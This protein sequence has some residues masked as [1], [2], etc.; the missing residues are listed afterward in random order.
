MPGRLS[1]PLLRE[2]AQAPL[3]P[4]LLASTALLPAAALLLAAGAARAQ[5][6]PAPNAGPTG[7]RVVAG[8]AA[9]TQTPGRTQITQSS[10]RAAIDWRQFN[11]G[12]D[13]HVDFRQPSAAS[14]TLNRVTG[15][16]PS[17]IAGR[18]TSNGGVA[19]VNPSGVVFADGAQVNVGSL[20]ASA[21]NI[22]NENFMAGRMAFD[23][24][25]R[26]GA[27]VENRGRVTVRERGLAAL[28]APE[29]RN[30]GVIRARLGRVALAG[31]AEAFT[32]DLAGDG[33]VAI[34][35]TR[36]V[37]QAPSGATALVTNSGVIEAEGGSVLLSAH[38][39]SGL[40]ETLVESGGRATT[41]AALATAGD[42]PDERESRRFDCRAVG[43]ETC[44]ALP[45][46][47]DEPL[48]ALV[49]LRLNRIGEDR[50]HQPVRDRLLAR[51]FLR[52]PALYQLRGRRG[53]LADPDVVL[54]DAIEDDY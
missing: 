4:R 46:V 28:V 35:V 24:P 43:A 27:R 26:P 47:V 25:P 54:P 42:R 32:L 15:P 29:V 16:D 5:P 11:V 14:W 45:T 50:P 21:A 40:V 10:D 53:R 41:D 39:A 6:L 7:G 2:A 37:R 30:S 19:L 18:V 49:S 44:P 20:I 22:T 23:G 38:A 13:H 3:R 36:A 52:E 51:L 12:R 33:L 8:S 17:V 1:P 31:G 48:R 34:D 9:I